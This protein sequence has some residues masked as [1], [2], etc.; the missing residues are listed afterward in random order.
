MKNTIYEK[1]LLVPILL[2]IGL[3]YVSC[4]HSLVVAA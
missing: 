1:V 3:S 4:L 2:T